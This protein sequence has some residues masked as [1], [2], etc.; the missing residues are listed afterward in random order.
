M[1]PTDAILLVGHPHGERGEKPLVKA[2]INILNNLLNN[3][4]KSLRRERDAG[5][6]RPKRP[7]MQ[8]LYYIGPSVVIASALISMACLVSIHCARQRRSTNTGIL[9]LYVE[10]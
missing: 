8:S 2:A 5:N 4:G 1:R 6:T 7:T 3:Q 9:P 10:N